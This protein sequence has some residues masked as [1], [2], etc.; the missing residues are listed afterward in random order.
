MLSSEGIQPARE[1]LPT[2]RDFPEDGGVRAH[3]RE[4]LEIYAAL[5]ESPRLITGRG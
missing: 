4:C 1:R 2:L 3:V 5:R